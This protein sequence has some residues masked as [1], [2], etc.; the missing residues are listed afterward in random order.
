[1]KR[2]ARRRLD[3]VGNQWRSLPQPVNIVPRGGWINAIREAICKS[4]V[5]L[6]QRMG[7]R[8]STVAKLEESER[9]RTIR[10]DSLQRAAEAI[11]C[12]LVYALVPRKSLQSIVDNQR[13]RLFADIVARTDHHMKLEGQNV[14]DPDWRSN[15]LRQAEE[16]I[17]D[18]Q[19]WRERA[20]G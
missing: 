11:D 20:G 18:N 9:N 3:D 15:L 6:G 8:G 5:D 13:L 2:L 4:Q 14:N 12:E 7:V 10:L 19:L 17:P 16:M 1:M